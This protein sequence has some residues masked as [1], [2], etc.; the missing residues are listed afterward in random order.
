[1]F[2]QFERMDMTQEPKRQCL[3]PVIWLYVFPELFKHRFKLRKHNMKGVKP[4]Y[5]LLCNHNAFI[6]FRVAGRAVFPRRSNYVSAINA[7]VGQEWLVRTVGC[8]C[9]RRYNSDPLLVRQLRR[10]VKRGDVAV[11]YPEAR[12]TL[13]GTPTVLPAS[14]GKLVKF[15]KELEV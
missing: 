14:L 5:L 10:V 4:P 7:Y 6:D 15:L 11:M 9:T 3:R 8:I 12:Y 2:D 13:C 1:M